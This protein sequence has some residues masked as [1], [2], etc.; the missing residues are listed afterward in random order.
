MDKKV[1]GDRLTAMASVFG[2][3]Y[4]SLIK[5]LKDNCDDKNKHDLVKAL[6]IVKTLAV[7]IRRLTVELNSGVTV[8]VK[9]FD[10]MLNI[11][12]K[13]I[14]LHKILKKPVLTDCKFTKCKKELIIL[15]KPEGKQKLYNLKM[16]KRHI[17][18]GKKQIV[19]L[20]KMMTKLKPTRKL[21]KTSSKTH[22]KL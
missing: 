3:E 10:L 8:S 7:D 19:S 2:N 15:S 5:C 14:N 11:I 20:K 4:I 18:Q 6:E 22:K 12:D 21:K 9:V 1:I 16:Y 17:E 13:L